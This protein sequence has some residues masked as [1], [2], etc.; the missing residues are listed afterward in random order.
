MEPLAIAKQGFDPGLTRP[1]AFAAPSSQVA[2]AAK[3]AERKNLNSEL[4]STRREIL[5][6]L[7]HRKHLKAQVNA[8][9]PSA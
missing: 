6:L 2:N 7:R 3:A 9:S 5:S 1:V 8:L 4:I